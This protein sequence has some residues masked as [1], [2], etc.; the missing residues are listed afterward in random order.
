MKSKIQ[1]VTYKSPHVKA[2]VNALLGPFLRSTTSG[3]EVG[4]LLFKHE[5]EMSDATIANAPKG[6]YSP[7]YT[8]AM[9][10]SK[11]DAT[12]H[13][14][15]ARETYR[16][17]V[18][19]L[20]DKGLSSVLAEHDAQV[21]ITGAFVEWFF[22]YCDRYQSA[23]K[24]QA[25]IKSKG[26]KTLG[27]GKTRTLSDRIPPFLIM[28]GELTGSEYGM[29]ENEDIDV[30]HIFEMAMDQLLPVME[31]LDHISFGL[32]LTKVQSSRGNTTLPD[33]T[34]VEFVS[35]DVFEMM[36]HPWNRVFRNKHARRMLREVFVSR[37]APEACGIAKD[38]II[39]EG[40]QNFFIPSMI[41]S[42][43]SPSAVF[44]AICA[45]VD[46]MTPL[47]TADYARNSAD[48]GD[49]FRTKG[50][51]VRAIFI[52]RTIDVTKPSNLN[53]LL[54]G[55]SI[56]SFDGENILTV[57]NTPCGTGGLGSENI[58]L[59]DRA[60]P[61]TGMIPFYSNYTDSMPGIAV[62]IGNSFALPN[63]ILDISSAREMTVLDWADFLRW[64][65]S[66][67]S[68]NLKQLLRETGRTRRD[69]KHLATSIKSPLNTSHHCH[70]TVKEWCSFKSLCVVKLRQVGP[71]RS[72]RSNPIGYCCRIRTCCTSW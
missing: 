23:A 20:S 21:H 50:D 72:A 31:A 62:P 40:N 67:F 53:V 13:L 46:G 18:G 26:T 55:I 56:E 3:A 68:T 69:L 43:T 61:I 24:A 34:A 59:S 7:K 49:V 63:Q 39:A 16:D 66:T 1:A 36:T 41:M 9:R 19:G 71:I 48:F 42:N 37:I 32:C 47:T 10:P 54:A 5:L 29:T 22:D 64:Y 27:Y 52:D 44:D 14:A 12:A 4:G 25:L 6:Y 45:H 2:V 17:E 65:R 8:H 30:N 57:G 51:L 15:L 28:S 35:P 38:Y 60:N 33:G 11:I 58:I 70:I